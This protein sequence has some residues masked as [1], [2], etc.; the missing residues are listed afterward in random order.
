MLST[1]I[2][3]A[4]VSGVFPSGLPISNLYVVV[5]SS[6]RA[7][8]PTHLML[9]GLI[10]LI[11]LGEDYISCSSSLCS[12]IHPHVIQ[13]LPAFLYKNR[14]A[15]PIFHK[16]LHAER[17]GTRR[18]ILLRSTALLFSV[19]CSMISYAIT[20]MYVRFEVFTAVAMRNVFF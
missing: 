2:C 9:L 10:I 13:F 19:T 4:L 7:T 1:H 3:L 20:D 14:F 8:C 6:N 12:C 15:A 5:F 11:I 17:L 18:I 16:L